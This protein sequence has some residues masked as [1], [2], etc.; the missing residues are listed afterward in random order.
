MLVLE[1]RF[2]KE[3]RGKLGYLQAEMIEVFI[4]FY[5]DLSSGI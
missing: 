1:K 3:D 2:G 4:P 5:G